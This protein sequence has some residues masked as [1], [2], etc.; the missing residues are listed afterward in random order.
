MKTR[1]KIYV[2]GPYSGSNILEILE[3][4]KRGNKTAA[5]LIKKGFAAFSPFLDYQY[6]FFEDLTIEDYQEFSIAFLPVCEGILVLPGWRKSKGTRKEIDLASDLGIPIFYSKKD[7]YDW[8][9]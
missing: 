7:L 3:N 2:A 5:E 6:S 4:I 9:K 8:F 1:I